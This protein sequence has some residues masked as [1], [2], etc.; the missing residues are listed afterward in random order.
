MLLLDQIIEKFIKLHKPQDKC[1]NIEKTPP[2]LKIKESKAMFDSL[3][4]FS[5]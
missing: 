5:F 1:L 4:T 2:N 3:L